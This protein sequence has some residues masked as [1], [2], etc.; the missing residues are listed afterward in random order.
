MVSLR[1]PNSLI[2]PLG[3]IQ[4][5]CVFGVR[6]K[7]RHAVAKVQL[8]ECKHWKLCLVNCIYVS[9]SVCVCVLFQSF[10]SLRVSLYEDR[11]NG[12]Y[13]TL[14]CKAILGTDGSEFQRVADCAD[15]PTG[16]IR[17]HRSCRPSD[18]IQFYYTAKIQ[19]R[20]KV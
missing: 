15:I 19:R 12:L 2:I 14:K 6:V 3:C 13:H 9:V 11:G 5:V 10:S 4:Y 8:S 16:T 17:R 1:S 18:L 20:D 7:L